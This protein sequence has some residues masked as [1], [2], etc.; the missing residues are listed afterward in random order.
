MNQSHLLVLTA[1]CALGA[2][3]Q[4]GSHVKATIGIGNPVASVKLLVSVVSELAIWAERPIQT[5]DLDALADQVK[6]A[7]S[8]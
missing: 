2:T 7:A 5:P 1:I 8:R 6:E 3:R 4:M